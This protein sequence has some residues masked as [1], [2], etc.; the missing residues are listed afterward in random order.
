MSLIHYWNLITRKIKVIKPASFFSLKNIFAVFQAKKRSIQG[1]P[2]YL[3]EQII[4]RRTMVKEKSP[5]CWEKGHCI[6]CG[7]EII[8]KTMEDRACSISEVPEMLADNI[9]PCYPEMMKEE[10]WEKYKI[11]NKIKLFEL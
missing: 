5:E 10:Q 11:D 7:C 9:Q 6:V 1:V 4:W 8:G 3:Y 2:S